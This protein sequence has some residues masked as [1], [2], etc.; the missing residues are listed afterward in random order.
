MTRKL[1]AFAAVAF[2][3]PGVCRADLAGFMKKPEPAY[4]WQLKSTTKFDGGTLYD[5]QMTSQTWQG[6]EWK[7]RIQVY[8]PDQPASADFCTLLNTGGSGS[9]ED[10][11]LASVFCKLT[12]NTFA[13][14]YNIPNQPL[15]GGKSEDALI[16]Y[17]WQ[18]F[19]AT[20]DETWPLHFPMA[21]AVLKA[22]DTI[23]AM[24]RQEKLAPINRFVV[25]GASK[26]GWTT[27]LVGAS[28]DPRVIG[29]APMVIDVLNVR[30]QMKQQLEYYG[31]PSEQV[32]DYT[33]AG[34]DKLMSAPRSDKLMEL[35]DPY[36]YR[37]IMTLPKLVVL[38]T[39]DRY[40]TVDA[41]NLYWDGLVGPK[42]VAYIPNSG[43]GLEDRF[44][45]LNAIS[46]FAA[47]LAA[48][49]PM[50]R[51]GWSYKQ[52]AAGWELTM[53]SDLPMKSTRLISAASATR[54]FRGSRFAIKQVQG[55][56]TGATMLIP[57]PATGYTAGYGEA[58]YEIGGHKFTLTTQVKMFGSTH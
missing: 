34:M 15:Y 6:M 11:L 46:G 9:V 40:W 7:H 38:G 48:R 1:L 56:P 16:V 22:M 32:E 24:A 4:K 5:M 33:A 36:S 26:R 28:R 21:K 8:R 13:V 25:T 54:D 50:P 58:E 52:T 19:L 53:T 37:T 44:R 29:I 30:K 27:W 3:L 45:A 42:W 20:G 51:L 18:Q 17:T 31:Q 23:Q 55:T 41:L 49:R 2:I 12:G 10:T 14:L 35:E 43:H 39:N 47:S 57:T